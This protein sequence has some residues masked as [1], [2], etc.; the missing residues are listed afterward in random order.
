MPDLTKK[1]TAPPISPPSP[2]PSG[3][4]DP[5]KP[6]Y[7]GPFPWE[8][9]P[10]FRFTFLAWFTRPGDRELLEGI[11]R[12]LYDMAL[13][14]CGK[15]PKP[16]ES[17]TRAEMRAA[18]QDLRHVEAFLLSLGTSRTTSSLQGEDERLAL[19]AE[20]WAGHVG[21]IAKGIEGAVWPLQG[22]GGSYY[23]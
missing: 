12:L 7:S 1:S 19:M 15:W 21:Q 20:S 8:E 18:A 9:H 2:P 23:P 3:I 11:G 14:I 10:A 16:Q 17:T 5:R 22:T 4:W 6:W 13:E